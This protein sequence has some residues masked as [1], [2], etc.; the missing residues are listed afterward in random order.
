MRPWISDA[1]PPKF[2]AN[3]E[4]GRVLVEAVTGQRVKATLVTI[5]YTVP[6]RPFT[7]KRADQG[8]RRRFNT[9]EHDAAKRMHWQAWAAAKA[10]RPWD[11]EGA[12]AVGVV[13]YYADAK[14]GDLDKLQGIVYDALEGHA[15]TKDRKIRSVLHP[16]GIVCDG[17]PERVEV[18]ITRLSVDPV[19]D[20]AARKR[21][22]R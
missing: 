6:G 15:W 19:Q 8:G 14:C 4:A 3:I 5:S 16:T 17:S 1:K 12:F 11:T 9:K 21:A 18:V 10:G 7:W 22:K 13:G 2:P 20:A